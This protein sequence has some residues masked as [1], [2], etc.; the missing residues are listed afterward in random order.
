MKEETWH[1]LIVI[2]SMFLLAL[3]VSAYIFHSDILREVGIIVLCFLLV[4][5]AAGVVVALLVNLTGQSLF[6]PLD[7]FLDEDPRKRC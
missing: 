4:S 6:D 3:T 7:S 2:G 5:I 1:L